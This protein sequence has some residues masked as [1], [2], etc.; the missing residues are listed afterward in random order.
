MQNRYDKI[1]PS[2]VCQAQSKH[3]G[4]TVDVLGGLIGS[5][6]DSL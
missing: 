1:R 6:Y 3:Q 2:I 4:D 5:R